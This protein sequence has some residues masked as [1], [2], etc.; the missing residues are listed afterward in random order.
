MRSKVGR[1]KLGELSIIIYSQKLRGLNH[2]NNKDFT[3]SSKTCSG[4]YIALCYV[5]LFPCDW[6]V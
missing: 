4:G 5:L 2:D 3:Q 1:K 6:G